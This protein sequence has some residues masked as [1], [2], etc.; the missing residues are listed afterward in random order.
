MSPFDVIYNDNLFS[1]YVILH[2]LFSS[3]DV[4]YNDNLFSSYVILHMLFSSFDVIYNI[5]LTTNY[6]YWITGEDINPTYK[7]ATRQ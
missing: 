2:M 1:S 5:N 6:K 4:I 3:F 7:V